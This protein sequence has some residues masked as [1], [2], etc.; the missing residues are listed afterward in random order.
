MSV[1]Y[2]LPAA[3]RQ[4]G[5]KPSVGGTPAKA[6][7]LSASDALASL[8]TA[9][10]ALDSDEKKADGALPAD[11]EEL[12][13]AY[14][15][16]SLARTKLNALSGELAAMKARHL[17]LMDGI[18]A[19]Y[20]ALQTASRAH[21]E[22][23]VDEVKAR[24]SLRLKENKATMEE[25][26]EEIVLL[27]E[28]Q[29]QRNANYRAEVKSAVKE[30]GRLQQLLIAA[31]AEVATLRAQHDEESAKFA[32]RKDEIDQLMANRV[33]KEEHE[34]LQRQRDALQAQQEQEAKDFAERSAALTTEGDEVRAA[35]AALQSTFD[36][37][38]AEHTA[39]QA[40][41]AEKEEALATAR[42][43]AEQI[44][45]SLSTAEESVASLTAQMAEANS[46]NEAALEAARAETSQLQERLSQQ[47][48]RVSDLETQLSTAQAL[49]AAGGSGSGDGPARLV[50]VPDPELQ[51]KV[52]ALES[53]MNKLL[54]ENVDLA[55]VLNEREDA[56]QA[57]N[58]ALAAAKSQAKDSTILPSG[59]AVAVAGGEDEESEY[60]DQEVQEE[61]TEDVP[62]PSAAASSDVDPRR[63]A[64]ASDLSSVES[65]LSGHQ[66]S[67]SALEKELK[68]KVADYKARLAE[69]K[70]DNAP[71]EIEAQCN[72]QLKDDKDQ[73][74]D[75]RPADIQQLEQ[76]LTWSKSQASTKPELAR[77]VAELKANKAT[78][79]SNKGVLAELKA[80]IGEL[81]ASGA[82][83]SAETIKEK[84]KEFVALRTQMQSD[85]TTLKTNYAQ[86]ETDLKDFKAR[87]GEVQALYARFHIDDEHP[88]DKPRKLSGEAQE[89]IER[90]LG[91]IAAKSKER[92]ALKALNAEI[93]E[94]NTQLKAIKAER[95]QTL[96]KQKQ[97]QQQIDALPPAPAG[98][99]APRTIK[100][101]TMRT[102]TKR[103]KKPKRAKSSSGAVAAAPGSG[104]S[105]APHVP[106]A[107]LG[108]LRPI[109]LKGKGRFPVREFVPI[110][111]A[112]FKPPSADAV[113]L[114]TPDSAGGSDPALQAKYD[115][116]QAKY[117]KLQA[118][119]DALKL[120]SGGS[121][122]VLEAKEKE[123]AQMREQIRILTEENPDERV[124]A[125]SAQLAS[126]R[127]EVDAAN[128]KHATRL[129]EATQLANSA[130]AE[131]AA[132]ESE[133]AK[134]KSD[135]QA[136]QDKVKQANAKARAAAAAGG[137][138]AGGAAAA[139]GGVPGGVDPTVV[140]E[141]EGRI[142]DLESSVESTTSERDAHAATIAELQKRIAQL[143]ADA[144][145]HSG[146]L[147]EQLE[148]R[149]A[150]LNAAH[151]AKVAELESQI[152]EGLEKLRITKKK[153]KELHEALQAE[154]SKREGLETNVS[155]LTTKISTME[156]STAE[157]LAA[158]D[159]LKGE[160]KAREGVIEKKESEISELQS[161]QA[162]LKE[163]VGFLEVR[164]V[165]EIKRRKE[166]QFK[167]ED[168]KGKVR[169]YAR[170][171][172]FSKKE[173]A[174]NEK[175]LLRPGTN[176][177]TL[178][179]NETQK[180]YQ[181]VVTDN[182]R[183]I[184]FDHVFQF[185]LE[186]TKGNAS[187]VEIFEE[188]KMFAE[189]AVQGINCCIFAYGQSGT[190]KCFG[191]GTELMMYDGSFKKVEDI[192]RDSRA[193]QE[194]L[195]MGDDSTPRR[196]MPG[197]EVQ[198]TG[199][200]YTITSEDKG[201]HVWRAN[202]DHI[203]VLRINTKPARSFE[204]ETG[205][206]VVGRLVLQPA[207]DDDL[208]GQRSMLPQWSSEYFCGDDADQLSQDALAAQLAQWPADG[209]RFECTVRDYL[210]LTSSER[211]ELTM[212]QPELV[213]FPAPEYSLEQR[214]RAVLKERADNVTAELVQRT[215]WV[216]G[217]SITDG[218]PHM[219]QLKSAHPDVIRALDEWY[220]V[221]DG[222][223]LVSDASVLSDGVVLRELLQS[224]QV[225]DKQQ[226]MPLELLREGP[227]I[228]RAL[229]EGII[230][231]NGHFDNRTDCFELLAKERKAIDGIVHLARGL[232][233]V[234]GAVDETKGENAT[235]YCVHVSGA[236]LHLL[237]PA[238]V[239]KRCPSTHSSKDQRC[240]GFDIAAAEMGEY[241]GF[242]VEGA[243]KCFLMADFV[244]THNTF[245]MAGVKPNEGNGFTRDLLGLKPRM[246]ERVYEMK[247]ELRKTHDIA[248]SSYMLE[249]YLNK[250]EDVFWK[251][252]T[253]QKYVGK[254]KAKWPEPPELKVRVD[255]KR[256]VTI[257][258]SV[259]LTFD[260]H[261][262]MQ[263]FCDEAEAMRRVRKTG[264]NEESSRSHLIFALI[265]TATDKK[266]GKKTTGKLS[267]VDLAGSERSD[268]TN[269]E[270]LSKAQRAAMMEEG[271]A[272]NESLR[273]L[274]SV[275]RILGEANKPLAKGQKA[276][277]V[278]YRGN[279][280]TELMQDSLGGNAKTLMFVNVGPAASNISESVDSLAYGDLVKNITNEKVS[281][282]ADLEE[283]LRFLQVQLR[284]Y[285][286]KFGPLS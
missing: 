167:Y 229:L 257:D 44:K 144:V 65:T 103:V 50:M 253:H 245:T 106:A 226:H 93:S 119:L 95:E 172:P 169:V 273:M 196:V 235:S 140:A 133:I 66:T 193:G 129:A 231:G 203:L 286:A 24:A 6:R 147:T 259:I 18:A 77:R 108:G 124:N 242:G 248:I 255:A 278:Q 75:L 14:I 165:E 101:T 27:Q 71:K 200:L 277:I 12:E 266:T 176:E 158:V 173:I 272:I 110:T 155:E 97:L 94:Q 72:F 246:I 35:L 5:F 204:P 185:G 45:A 61:V 78:L 127:A 194:Q 113:K 275:F 239:S 179:I 161:T 201:R 222:A 240:A 1:T 92:D 41:L 52:R 171:R 159:G 8:S 274:K 26:R 166:F 143:E 152:T 182:W 154:T 7:L 234:T 283:Q 68:P 120:S 148:A 83:G 137:A 145:A 33:P 216:L 244:V 115:T 269:V 249:I 111:P 36:A 46:G 217:M 70:A 164:N 202:V 174:D 80:S 207:G 190:G 43:E 132:K 197:S 128:Q 157:A 284:A 184:E 150:E 223:P 279:M 84:E 241:W 42:A 81:K 243:N 3:S 139:G 209:L 67:I 60:E 186:N 206:W 100:K 250:L 247:T 19:R 183:P 189:L 170:V 34:E 141:L 51:S 130:R 199:R 9:A 177:W 285:E 23:V 232:G 54:R 62:D 25:M 135:V 142:S 258:N 96:E 215:A 47:E 102:V 11:D 156:S 224:Y 116:L 162:K 136:M 114:A 212:F 267:L 85:A 264:L 210:S 40:S 55:R 237:Q 208:L 105:S 13:R 4:V 82:E 180:N 30:Q 270:G 10:G 118:E 230:D 262:E 58:D 146:S 211:A 261:K 117:T 89:R 153:A 228:R 22:G 57:S 160:I 99:D 227:A 195:L 280:L 252:Q 276:E 187:Q 88:E 260:T 21:F 73:P 181:G 20:E 268:K 86:Y 191:T 134:L 149:S 219:S 221:V 138:A 87:E 265:I 53:E 15:P 168:A 107:L 90:L 271:I 220:S 38:Q 56:V 256:K 175:T 122:D 74:T 263:D 236:D 213:H 63:A 98:A 198:K 109:D 112:V 214:L 121:A 192:V 238:S 29:A 31:E 205:R 131:A 125:L 178:C 32:A 225:L 79:E 48:L 76:L 69:F 49:A 104:S 39:A 281:A 28:A 282:D 251:L 59:A 17:Q 126:Q 2:G 37:L 64:L 151:A 16:L 163:E 188:T 218:L 254:E 91:L 233:Y 123:L